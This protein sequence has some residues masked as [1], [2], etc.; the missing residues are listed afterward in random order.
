MPL[1]L[2]L[3]GVGNLL[4]QLEEHA[5]MNIDASTTMIC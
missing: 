5:Y 2:L 1:E 4:S 3:F